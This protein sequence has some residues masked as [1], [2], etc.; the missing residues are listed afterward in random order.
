M[1][2][3]TPHALISQCCFVEP[4]DYLQCH[5]AASPAHA[6]L[7]RAGATEDEIAHYQMLLTSAGKR[8]GRFNPITNI[9]DGKLF[10][11]SAIGLDVVAKSKRSYQDYLGAG[12]VKAI[13]S[14]EGCT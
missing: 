13:A 7:T 12:Y 8:F 1:W 3:Q 5:L 4:K 14:L 11:K 10:S 2:C 6:V 9:F